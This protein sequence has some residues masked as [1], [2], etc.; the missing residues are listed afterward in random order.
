MTTSGPI[1]NMFCSC[2]QRAVR[3]QSPNITLAGAQVHV[4]VKIPNKVSG[5]ERNL[6]EKLKEL[7]G[8]K[9]KVGGRGWF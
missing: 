4:R 3:E 6:V 8:S 2:S 9:E 5:E 1:W 7:E